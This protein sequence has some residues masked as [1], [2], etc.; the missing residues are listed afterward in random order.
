MRRAAKILNTARGKAGCFISIKAK[1]CIICIA[2]ARRW[3]EL[4]MEH[5]SGLSPIHKT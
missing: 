1:C 4:F 5:S 2:R 3:F